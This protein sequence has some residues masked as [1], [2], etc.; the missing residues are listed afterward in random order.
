MFET[1]DAYVFPCYNHKK[2][3]FRKSNYNRHIDRH[4]AIEGEKGRTEI[5]K[6]L[7][8]PLVVTSHAQ[9][10]GNGVTIRKCQTFYRIVKKQS[11]GG[12]KFK[13]DYWQVI[14]INNRLAKRWEI[15]TAIYEE[16]SPEYA[17]INNKIER[18]LWDNRPRESK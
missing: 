11:I 7:V 13:L 5:E 15:A 9:R 1:P 6:T 3:Y 2:V 10:D 18:I 12:G 16:S 4:Y 14:I 17:M 8:N